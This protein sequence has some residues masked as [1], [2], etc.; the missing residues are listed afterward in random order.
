[1]SLCLFSLSVIRP[2]PKLHSTSGRGDEDQHL[3]SG[4]LGDVRGLGTVPASRIRYVRG[5]SWFSIHP[6]NRV[7]SAHLCVHAGECTHS[8][9]SLQQPAHS[10]WGVGRGQRKE[11]SA[12]GSLDK[13]RALNDLRQESVKTM[14]KRQLNLIL[15]VE[16]PFTSWAAT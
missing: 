12:K 1:M 10:L 14:A 3:P 8:S 9:Q 2:Y 7:L 13:C 6:F 5:K 15:M 11:R 16:G 4:L